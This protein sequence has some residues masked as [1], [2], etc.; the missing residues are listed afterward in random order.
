M[1]MLFHPFAASS[2]TVAEGV[3]MV[4]DP[5]VLDG[6]IGVAQDGT[7]HW[8]DACER[9]MAQQWVV[10]RCERGMRVQT[11]DFLGDVTCSWC[12]PGATA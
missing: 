9:A 10:T 11:V 8:L 12:E 7:R 5:E 4:T 3:E 2:V 6:A 1:T